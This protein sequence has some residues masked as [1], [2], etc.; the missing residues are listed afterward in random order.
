MTLLKAVKMIHRTI[1]KK[2][3]LRKILLYC[4]LTISNIKYRNELCLLKYSISSLT[5]TFLE[6]HRMGPVRIIIS[7]NL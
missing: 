5:K 3:T 6:T 7:G 4:D 2:T 1:S